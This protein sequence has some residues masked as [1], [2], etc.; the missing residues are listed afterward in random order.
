MLNHA[1]KVNG[2]VEEKWF[3][4]KSFENNLKW[5]FYEIQ[6]ENC[7]LWFNDV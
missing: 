6:F 3:Y 1:S 2:M 4:L 7:L 5:K